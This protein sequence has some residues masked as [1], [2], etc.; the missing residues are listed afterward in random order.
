MPAV[1]I[2]DTQYLL[3]ELHEE[4]MVSCYYVDA[5][6]QFDAGL[7]FLRDLLGYPTGNSS[8]ISINAPMSVYLLNRTVPHITCLV[9]TVNKVEI[10][11][12]E[13]LANI[14]TRNN[15]HHL[16][17]RCGQ[18]FMLVDQKVS[19]SIIYLAE[20]MGTEYWTE[21]F[22]P[23]FHECLRILSIFDA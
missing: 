22:C 14:R 9:G 5:S 4:Y 13:D 10:V 21:L 8:Q 7:N 3:V 11:I 6:G 20:N 1:K 17:T 23:F 15:S 12:E 2:V 19:K 16:I 18:H